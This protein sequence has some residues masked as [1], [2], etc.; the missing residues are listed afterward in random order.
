MAGWRCRSEFSCC[1]AKETPRDTSRCVRCSMCALRIMQRHFLGDN[2][3]S[4]FRTAQDT[5]SEPDERRQALAAVMI[6]FAVAILL[7]MLPGTT[8]LGGGGFNL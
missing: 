4:V 5:V 2:S 6:V 7:P 1:S 8:D 3:L